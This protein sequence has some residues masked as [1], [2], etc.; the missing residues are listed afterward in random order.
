MRT[1]TFVLLAAVGAAALILFKTEKGAAL[2]KDLKEKA[3]DKA[4]LW[5]GRLSKIGNEA[6]DTVD[7]LR[8]MLGS[9]MEGLSDDARTRLEK[10]VNGTGKSAGKLKKNIGKQLAS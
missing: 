6:V 7:E 2:R 10:V 1:T 9:E 5:K 3:K 8:D 4:D